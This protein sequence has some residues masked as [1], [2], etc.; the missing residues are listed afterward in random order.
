MNFPV[1]IPRDDRPSFG[2]RAKDTRG[3]C[4]FYSHTWSRYCYFYWL[5]GIGWHI[6][7]IKPAFES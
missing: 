4:P 1:I 7:C 5:Q 6:A 3:I 2:I